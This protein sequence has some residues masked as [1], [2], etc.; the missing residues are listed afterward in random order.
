MQGMRHIIN[1]VDWE[2]H[3]MSSCCQ[4]ESCCKL[5]VSADGAQCC[6]CNPC[7]KLE[8]RFCK[9]NGNDC[10][11]LQLLCDG[12]ECCSCD[13]KK[14]ITLTFKANGDKVPCC[15]IKGITDGKAC[16]EC[17]PK[18]ELQVTVKACEGGCNGAAWCVTNTCDGQECCKCNA[19][20]SLVLE[21][22]KAWAYGLHITLKLTNFLC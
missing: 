16:C 14:E 2:F 13:P 15:T 10:C 20:E 19:N 3:L 21:L 22:A 1:Y 12:K 7:C 5:Q 18:K 8:A 4:G 17:S 6:E 9:C 11:K